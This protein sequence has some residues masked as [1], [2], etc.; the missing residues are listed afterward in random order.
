LYSVALIF[1]IRYIF[2]PNNVLL[3]EMLNDTGSEEGPGAYLHN[4]MTIVD[5]Q[6]VTVGSV[7]FSNRSW[8]HDSEVMLSIGGLGGVVL[9]VDSPPSA[10][11]AQQ[12]RLLRWSRH[13]GQATDK[14]L[15]LPDALALWASL[16]RTSRVRRWTPSL[17]LMDT[18]TQAIYKTFYAVIADPA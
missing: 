15:P 14:V 4:K 13:L 1:G 2:V 8:T 7:N 18:A 3:F 9:S 10:S 11:I 5:D 12:V 17:N 6:V 16:P